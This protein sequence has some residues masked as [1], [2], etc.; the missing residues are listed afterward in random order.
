VIDIKTDYLYKYYN[1][2]HWMNYTPFEPQYYK[3]EP[4][5][6]AAGLKIED[7][8]QSFSNGRADLSFIE[9]DNYGDVIAEHD[10]LHL[11]YIR[12]KFLL[13]ALS[14]YNYSI[15]LSWQ[16][17]W[18]FY[19]YI[20]YGHLY[21]KDKYLKATKDCT[22]ESLR[23][24]LRYR[25]N[26]NLYLNIDNFFNSNLTRKVREKYNNLKHRGTFHFNGLGIQDDTLAISVDGYR[27]KMFKRPTI[28]LYEWKKVLTAFDIH[29]KSYFEYLIRVTMPRDYL[30]MSY[31]L[32]APLEYHEKVKRYL[33]IH[34]E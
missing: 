14:N 29:F 7:V 13:S 16:M 18:L 6:I 26:Y 4:Y 17:I 11:N 24:L 10:E 2:E 32:L 31:D 25:K 23:E 8:Y 5:V 1:V 19:G 12:S 3:N 33:G 21:D 20:D 9:V 28:D 34:K 30:D 22:L 27:H 15:D